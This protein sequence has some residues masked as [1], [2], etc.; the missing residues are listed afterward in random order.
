[1]FGEDLSRF[2]QESLHSFSF[3]HQS[4]ESLHNRQNVLKR[5]IEFMKDKAGWAA[6]SPGL[7]EAHAKVSG[8]QEVQSMVEL[9]QRANLLRPDSAKSIGVGLGPLTGPADTS[10]DNLFDKSFLPISESPTREE[11]A[12][13]GRPPRSASP[14]G[15]SP[16][17]ARSGANTALSFANLDRIRS[18]ESVDTGPS[19]LLGRRSQLKRTFTDVEGYSLQNKLTEVLAQPYMM[20]DKTRDSQI[21]SPKHAPTMNGPPKRN[22]TMHATSAAHSHGTRQNAAAQAIFTTE[23]R[24][25]WTI[26]AANDLACLVF[27]VTKA[28]VRKM[29][30]ME[31]IRAE[32]RNWLEG[33]LRQTELETTRRTSGQ[34]RE[35]SPS[36]SPSSTMGNGV[37]AKLLSKPPSRQ[38]YQSRRSR[39][40][41]GGQVDQST[42]RLSRSVSVNNRKSRG[43]L[44]CGDV[45]PIQKRNG[46]VGSASLWV[47]EKQGNL[48]WV[49]EEI[50]ED[51]ANISVDEV[52]C[53]TKGSG[54]IEAIFGIE[55]VR[56]GMDVKKL[57]PH[58]PKQSGTHTG[59]L[60]YD[61]LS[62][63][64]R[65]T[66]RTS[67]SINIPVTVDLLP[68]EPTIRVSSFPHIA[69][70]IV[71]SSESLKI[72][73]SNSVF[74][75]ALF[76]HEN[77]DGL[78]ITE[79]LPLFDDLLHLI[80]DEDDIDF[81]DGIVIPEHSFR[82]A[83]AL[84][85]VR[86]GRADA[87]SIFLRPSGL[88]AKHRDGSEIMVDVQ[89]RVVKSE[90]R[91]GPDEDTIIEEREEGIATPELESE[92]SYALWI[93]YSRQLHA[94]NHGIGPIT[95]LIMSRPGT[96]PHQPSPGQASPR[97]S[98][99]E[100]EKDSDQEDSVQSALVLQ[101]QEAHHNQSSHQLTQSLTNMLH[102]LHSPLGQL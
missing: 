53:A 1:M 42:G 66:A 72:T 29:G 90:R 31:V 25:P 93:T 61:E 62:E 21:L 64:R 89:M 71:L 60:D 84:L 97:I 15:L 82:R 69:G 80:S 13:T 95:P 9:L 51:V 5:S 11:D 10:G 37:T 77:P 63:V 12:V 54:S 101:L 40:A 86:H 48:I 38:T 32:R 28:E 88:P 68:D 7:V 92:V 3:A 56:R 14:D 16:M 102:L 94:V 55:R 87:A 52:G 83:R 100:S 59:A 58:L 26:T 17:T 39:T 46:A 81:R 43:V 73:S 35:K 65:Y 6:S 78:H 67:N 4:E 45:V 47:K 36:P 19:P 75:G 91:P 44:L 79:L 57:I 30:I 20:T 33:K 8:D 23:N 34:R 18:N 50:A 2:P 27:G 98:L 49:L 41:D 70:I 24:S 99:N 96:P 85:A 22:M 74:S 76:G